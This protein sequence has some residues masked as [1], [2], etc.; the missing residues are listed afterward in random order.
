MAGGADTIMKM[1][2]T[3]IDLKQF[4]DAIKYL[5][6]VASISSDIAFLKAAWNNKGMSAENKKGTMRNCW[7]YW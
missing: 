6:I 7:W 4:Q 2:I 3:L 5:E 1:A